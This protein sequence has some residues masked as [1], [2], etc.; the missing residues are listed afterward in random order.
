MVTPVKVGTIADPESGDFVLTMSGTAQMDWTA[1]LGTK[2]YE[3]DRSRLGWRIDIAREGEI[4]P[5]APYAFNYPDWWSSRVTITLPHTG[6]GFQVQGSDPVDKTVGDLFHFRRKVQFKDGVVTMEADTRALAAE[7]P[8]VRALRTR[9]EMV[10]LANGSV[11][12][13]APSD[14][15]PTEAEKEQTRRADAAEAAR[16]KLKG[17]PS[18]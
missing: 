7:L 10:E 1:D 15:E 2:W 6:K 4:N 9:T 17:K 16:A 5:D 18:K 3:I 8:A 13:R 12:I 11:Y 14:Y